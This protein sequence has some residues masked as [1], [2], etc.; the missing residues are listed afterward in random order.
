MV[1][2]RFI[3]KLKIG[4]RFVLLDL[5]VLPDCDPPWE[6]AGP[7][8]KF[9]PREVWQLIYRKLQE[10]CL[11]HFGEHN[12]S[13]RKVAVPYTLDREHEYRIL[14]R[15]NILLKFEFKD[16]NQRDVLNIVFNDSEKKLHKDCLCVQIWD[17]ARNMFRELQE[18]EKT[19]G[20]LQKE[21]EGLKTLPEPSQEYT[22]TPVKRSGSSGDVSLGHSEYVPTAINGNSPVQQTSYKPS[23]IV[24]TYKA[25]PD[26]YTPS[27]SQE[28]DST[29]IS[30]IPSSYTTPSP[31]QQTDQK[32]A[33]SS[34]G[35]NK[36][37]AKRR[38]READI[39]GQS[40]E[41]N[42]DKPSSST[43]KEHDSGSNQSA[44]NIFSEDSSPK[45][46]DLIGSSS[47]EIVLLMDNKRTQLPRKTKNQVLYKESI[48]PENKS[49]QAMS[50]KRRKKEGET[51][52]DGMSSKSTKSSS[53][54]LNK[55]G[56]LDEWCM[57]SKDSKS[58]SSTKKEGE[59]L[60]SSKHIS[61]PKDGE[62]HKRESKAKKESLPVTAVAAPPPVDREKLREEVETMR[63]TIASLQ[64]LERMLPEDKSNL[65][66]P[67]LDCFKLSIKDIQ[68]TFEDYRGELRRIFD[69]YKDLSERQ[70]QKANE[71]CYFTEVTSVMEDDQK[72]SMMQRLEV[73][74][75]PEEDRGKYTEFFSSVLI[76]EWGLRIWMKLFQYADRQEALDRIRLQEE[77]NPMELTSSNIGCLMASSN[78]KKR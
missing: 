34:S 57:R 10:V 71:L 54:A 23:K 37:V 1:L 14:E 62:K 28:T 35:E 12:G 68:D 55:S 30:Y 72:Y 26:P 18:K 46:V 63:K 76:M 39:F 48:T 7:E 36:V 42:E 25:K 40:D 59:W 29:K 61:K 45:A 4:K 69:R 17:D 56:V 15:P 32:S 49:C 50:S 13:V 65:D 70:W 51:T 41:E 60:A 9:V 78:K 47:D 16:V 73:E 11:K 38:R 6:S 21:N 5:V 8:N 2:S 75:V 66:V 19:V 53:S 77:A 64:K 44:E 74:F 3:E 52:K 27:S 24:D 67:I 20:R 58:S 33:V 31:K 43:K 22:P